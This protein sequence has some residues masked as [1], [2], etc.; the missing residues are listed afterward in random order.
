VLF[1]WYGSSEIIH[2]FSTV[3]IRK[4]FTEIRAS[5]FEEKSVLVVSV[6]GVLKILYKIIR[7]PYTDSK[8]SYHLL[9]LY[10]AKSSFLNQ[11]L[12]GRNCI[13][14]IPDISGGFCVA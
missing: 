2:I 14:V 11:L 9:L 12:V 6:G 13:H 3:T 10:F 7:F 4:N 5:R 8:M 1:H